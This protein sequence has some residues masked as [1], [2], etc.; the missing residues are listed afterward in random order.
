MNYHGKN[1]DPIRL[2]S[3]YCEVKEDQG[4][5]L[6]LTFCPNPNHLNSRSPAFQINQVK[7]WVHCFSNCGISGT[8]EHAICIIEGI[9]EKNNVSDEDLANAKSKPHFGEP[10]GIRRSRA[11]VQKSRREAKKIIFRRAVSNIHSGIS[12][13]RHTRLRADNS[14][15]DSQHELNEDTLRQYSYLPKEA[16]KYLEERGIDQ[17][18][19]SRWQIGFDEEIERLTIPA[20]DGKD[21]LKF[22]IKRAIK[23][24]QRPPY[25]YPDDSA[26]TSLL[27]GACNLDR[28]MVGSVGLIVVEGSIDAIRLHQHG[29]RNTVAIL[30]NSLSLKQREQIVRLSPKRVYLFMD[31]DDAGVR[32]L[33][34]ASAML[35]NKYPIKVPLYPKGKDL[36]PAK[37]TASQV[38]DA[39]GASVP[40]SRIKAKL[41]K[42]RK[43]SLVQSPI[44]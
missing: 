30:G 7:P 18:S 16:L 41:R 11:K 8:F 1:I 17:S 27:F 34:K 25:L 15:N 39:I 2:W 5:F 3:D 38:K 40:V 42:K 36:D 35:E 20:R 19:R 22:V 24:N 28:S 9:Y 37:L 21:R 13:K 29:Y 26:K 31:K 10:D 32:G 44:V 33:E 4:T 14:S 43:E 12:I 6:P 23:Q